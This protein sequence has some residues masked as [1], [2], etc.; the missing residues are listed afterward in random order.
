MK[1]LREESGMTLV[2][3]SIIV[4]IVGLLAVVG[5]PTLVN[6][7]PRI[8]MNNAAATLANQIALTRMTAIA[9]STDFRV[10][11]EPASERYFFEKF[12]GGAWVR[13]DTATLGSAVDLESVKY[14]DGTTAPA[15]LQLNASGST[16][17]PLNKVSVRITLQTPDAA[18]RRRVVVEPTGRIFTERWAGGTTW[19]EE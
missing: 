9:K 2:E 3:L 15:G 6:T 13:Y 8:R 12:S 14:A 17:V 16:G 5:V 1:R 11:F 18:A 4:S 19:A 10:S 7:M